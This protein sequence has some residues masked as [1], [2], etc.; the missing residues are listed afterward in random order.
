MKKVIFSLVLIFVA[1]AATNM[2]VAQ[3]SGAGIEFEKD[4]HDYGTMEQ[5]GDGTFEF[6]F[7][8]IGDAPLTI[9]NVKGSVGC[10]VLS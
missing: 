9:L 2:V 6:R 4:V 7:K 1:T 8:N 3:V 10:T 5:H